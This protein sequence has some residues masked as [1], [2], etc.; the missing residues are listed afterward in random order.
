MQDAFVYWSVFVL[1]WLP[2][3]P[4]QVCHAETGLW[5]IRNTCYGDLRLV[6]KNKWIWINEVSCYYIWF[7]IPLFSS[8]I[9]TAVNSGPSKIYCATSP[10]Q[11]VWFLMLW[12]I[13]SALSWLSGSQPWRQNRR[14]IIC[15]NL[16]LLLP[17]AGCDIQCSSGIPSERNKLYCC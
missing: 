10:W 4:F 13:F 2:R 1:F 17:L 11:G 8:K 5:L 15:Y 14:E 6:W 9:S 3:R 16:F 7:Q 12:P